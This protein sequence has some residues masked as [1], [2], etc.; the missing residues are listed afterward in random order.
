M[1]GFEAA[2]DGAVWTF[3]INGTDYQV[4]KLG[5]DAFMVQGEG[6][7]GPLVPNA[8]AAMDAIIDREETR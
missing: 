1:N 6:W 2:P 8:E 3:G 5:E 7:F 4:M